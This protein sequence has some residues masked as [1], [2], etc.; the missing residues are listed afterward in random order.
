MNFGS[1][2]ARTHVQSKTWYGMWSCYRLSYWALPFLCFLKKRINLPFVS[3]RNLL[4][5]TLRLLKMRHEFVQNQEHYK[6]TVMTQIHG[7]HAIIRLMRQTIQIPLHLHFHCMLLYWD[8]FVEWKFWH[9]IWL[10]YHILKSRPCE[11]SLTDFCTSAL[12]KAWPSAFLR[13]KKVDF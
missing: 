9:C 1:D 6:A 7:T 12:S 5:A 3:L 4:F 13:V 11:N 2:Q 10:S 8:C